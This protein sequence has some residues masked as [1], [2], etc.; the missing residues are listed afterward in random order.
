MNCQKN[1]RSPSIN[2]LLISKRLGDSYNLSDFASWKVLTK[3]EAEKP[4]GWRENES[5]ISQGL[6]DKQLRDKLCRG[7]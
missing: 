1:S 5:A 6:L 2:I 3:R 7:I 4:F